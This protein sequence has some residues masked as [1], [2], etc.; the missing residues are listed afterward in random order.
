MK[1]TQGMAIFGH[2]NVGFGGFT[3]NDNARVNDFASALFRF[4]ME[5]KL[6]PPQQDVVR[7]EGIVRALAW[8]LVDLRIDAHQGSLEEL[9]KRA[10][11]RVAKVAETVDL[12]ARRDIGG[13]GAI[14]WRA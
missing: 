7:A 6:E 12:N 2:L 4:Q 9:I 8:R 11:G 5:T 14:S 3:E 1:R 10:C 13:R